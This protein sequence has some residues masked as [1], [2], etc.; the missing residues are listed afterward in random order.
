L[1][2][3]THRIVLLAL[4]VVWVAVAW[5][6]LEGQFTAL[7]S[8]RQ[9]LEQRNMEERRALLDT[10]YIVARPVLA[11]TPPNACI[12][13]LAYTGPEH[14]NYYKTR[15]DYYLYPRRVVVQANSGA[16]AE[17]CPYVAVFRDSPANLRDEPFRGVWDEQQLRARVAGMQQAPSS[18]DVAV[19]RTGP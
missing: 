6:P 10:A 4:F 17:N 1:R 13:F 9:R 7:E 5:K 14:V 11:A 3:Y 15:L 18:P 2:R 12:L 8:W 19:Y 16:T